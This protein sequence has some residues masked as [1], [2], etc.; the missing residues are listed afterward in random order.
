MSRQDFYIPQKEKKISKILER[1]AKKYALRYLQ[2][3]V[4]YDT[5]VTYLARIKVIKTPQC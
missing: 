3:K 5:V 4:R 1:R 2:L